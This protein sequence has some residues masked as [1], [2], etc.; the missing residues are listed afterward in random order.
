MAKAKNKKVGMIKK[1]IA[2]IVKY[3]QS[4]KGRDDI[5][6]LDEKMKEDDLQYEQWKRD[7]ILWWHKIKDIPFTI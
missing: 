6:K 3:M 4:K 5:K 1:E 2:W 7:Q